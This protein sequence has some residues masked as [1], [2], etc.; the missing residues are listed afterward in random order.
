MIA[1]RASCRLDPEDKGDMTSEAESCEV[2]E[3]PSFCFNT[4]G[5]PM[6]ILVGHMLVDA[7]AGH[8]T[9]GGAYFEAF[10]SVLNAFGI[11]SIVIPFHKATI[12]VRVRDAGGATSSKEVRPIPLRLGNAIVCLRKC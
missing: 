5:L 4:N 9:C 7:A 2:I 8:P 11:Q 1:T 6:T 3:L 10:E 12:P